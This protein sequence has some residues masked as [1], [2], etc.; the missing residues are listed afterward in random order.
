LSAGAP[1]D[2]VRSRQCPSVGSHRSTTG[3]TYIRNPAS[4]AAARA[5]MVPARPLLR[6]GAPS[7]EIRFHIRVEHGGLPIARHV[8]QH[9]MPKAAQGQLRRRRDPDVPVPSGSHWRSAP[10][11]TRRPRRGKRIRKTG[12]S[13]RSLIRR[14]IISALAG[15]VPASAGIIIV[16]NARYTPA[17]NLVHRSAALDTGTA[18]ARRPRGWSL[19]PRSG[20]W[21]ANENPGAGAPTR[22]LLS[23]H[24]FGWILVCTR[25]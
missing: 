12:R 14:R 16:E 21:P 22:S 3:P 5:Q 23:V 7:H 13:A 4:A 25:A 9:R 2:S 11:P 19:W 20:S 15:D 24:S 6:Q 8:E 1:A 17:V 10:R 18:A